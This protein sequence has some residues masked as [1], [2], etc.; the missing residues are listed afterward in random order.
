MN[1][2]MKPSGL[3]DW[4]IDALILA[5]C[6]FD[7]AIATKLAQ[8]DNAWDPQKALQGK[9]KA[10]GYVVVIVIVEVT[11]WG[12]W[13]TADIAAG[14][15]LLAQAK[16]LGEEIRS[17]GRHVLSLLGWSPVVIEPEAK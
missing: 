15:G 3:A 9:K 6:L 7:W 1:P 11:R 16:L 2:W 13:P 4:Q 5:L 17:C 10:F 8:W 12:A 14:W